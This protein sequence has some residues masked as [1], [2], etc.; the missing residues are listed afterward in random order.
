MTNQTE[1]TKALNQRLVARALTVLE[2]QLQNRG[3]TADETLTDFLRLRS[4]GL[5]YESFTIIYFDDERRLMQCRVQPTRPCDEAAVLRDIARQALILDAAAVVIHHG[6][7]TG[8]CWPSF[9]HYE[10][11]EQLRTALNLIHVQ[12]L[13]H[14]ITTNEGAFSMRSMRSGKVIHGRVAENTGRPIS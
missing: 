9:E 6:Y 12:V 8:P 7:T 2:R 4:L 3:H 1:F 10:Q 11:A 14:V 13:D 5:A